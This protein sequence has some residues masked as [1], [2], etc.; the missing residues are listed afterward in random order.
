MLAPL[1]RVALNLEH[2]FSIEPT[3][4]YL[5]VGDQSKINLLVN[6]N[7]IRFNDFVCVL[8]TVDRHDVSTRTSLAVQRHP[9]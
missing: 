1:D 3:P 2:F 6:D 9:D 8:R 5:I 7:F 4:T